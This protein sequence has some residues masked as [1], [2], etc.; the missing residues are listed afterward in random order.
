M[1]L[2]HGKDV[3]GSRRQTQN[4]PTPSG[5]VWNEFKK[6]EKSSQNAFFEAH[7]FQMLS[8]SIDKF[9]LFLVHFELVILDFLFDEV[10]LLALL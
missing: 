7:L 1:V 10:V 3:W 6:I 2:Y 9:H 4:N 8:I 5:N